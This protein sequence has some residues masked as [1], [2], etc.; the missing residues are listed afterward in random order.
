M[1]EYALVLE[2]G[3]A[4]GAYQIGAIKALYER[5]YKFKAIVG[6]SIGAINAAFLCQD[7][8]NTIEKLWQTL[9]FSDIVNIEDEFV[10]K[11]I[12][13]Q[14]DFSVVKELR[15]NI[16]KTLKDRGIDTSLMRKLLNK[17]LDEEKIRNSNVRFGLVTFCISDM[18]PQ[19]VF[20]EDIPKGQLV[21]Y[22]L[23]SSNLP[24]FKRAK[25]DKKIFL[26]GGAFDNCSVEML[27]NAGY[28]NIIA[29]RLF[30]KNKIRN[31]STLIKNKDL[32]LKMFAPSVE[33]PYILNFETNNLNR[34]LE[35]GYF[36]TIKQLDKL[37]GYYY[38][39]N[40]ISEKDIAKLL[41]N[42]N[43]NISLNLVN[44]LGIKYKAGQ[45]IIDVA[46]EKAILK[47]SK[48]ASQKSSKILKRQIIS[49]VEYVAKKENININKIYDFNKFLNIVKQKIINN[50]EKNLK[51]NVEKAMYYF[52]ESI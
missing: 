51:S 20:I 50:K 25:I 32:C 21:D 38:T 22:L 26:D 34:L 36:D 15:N 16:N 5:G 1:K 8:I 12:G 28:K 17:Y 42:L 6:T 9:S 23:A 47:M 29:L 35:Y 14:I 41:E 43:P 49:I 31:Y 4:K 48:Y 3:G 33:L 27:Y 40:K 10:Q 39:F 46:K 52:I 24:V 19:E 44:M 30:T 18:K 13:K 7:G 37:D 2:G 11:V 45:N